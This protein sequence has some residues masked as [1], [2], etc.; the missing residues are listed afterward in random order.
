MGW[1]VIWRHDV[2]RELRSK[3]K[4]RNVRRIRR[5]FPVLA[6]WVSMSCYRIFVVLLSNRGHLYVIFVFF[7]SIVGWGLVN[8]IMLF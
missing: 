4:D 5:S 6:R 3:V 7:G 1:S 2:E 8:N